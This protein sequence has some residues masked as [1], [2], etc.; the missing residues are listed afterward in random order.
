MRPFILVRFLFFLLFPLLTTAFAAQP[1]ISVKA[2]VDKAFVTV[3]DRFQFKIEI[4]HDP[5]IDILTPDPV[6]RLRD[7]EIKSTRDIPPRKESGAVVEGKIFTLTSYTL[8]EYVIDPIAIRYRDI[9]G[10]NKE[11]K[12]NKLYITVESIDKSRSVK[13]DIRDIKSVVSLPSQL[14]KYILMILG[15]ILFL[16]LTG[17]AWL[18]FKRRDLLMSF[19]APPLKPHEEA[20]QSLLRLQD[21]GLLAKG[22]VRE[23]YFRMSEILKKYFEK[24]YGFKALERTNT[25]ILDEFFRIE[26][27]TDPFKIIQQFFDS[28]D[29]VKFAKFIPDP[30]EIQKDY[31]TAWSIV[32]KTQPLAEM[33]GEKS[34]VR[35]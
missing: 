4:R 10:K 18:F 24:R 3:G 2:S 27:A 20:F 1:T 21:S 31:K 32:E 25:E 13:K 6:K 14:L 19:F 35:Q 29:L 12:T 8:G 7:F 11:I 34:E 16:L 28:S 22:N 15:G 33:E 30:L 17:I 5:R 26:I 23:Y 9:D